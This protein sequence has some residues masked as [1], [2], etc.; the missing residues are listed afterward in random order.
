MIEILSPSTQERDKLVKRDLYSKYGVKEYWIVD[1]AGK[2]IEVMMQGHE[3]YM[4]HAVFLND[5]VLT[6]PLIGTYVVCLA[7]YSKMY[8]QY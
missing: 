1:P 4:L 8:S 6:S 2:N 7:R 5:E 3:G